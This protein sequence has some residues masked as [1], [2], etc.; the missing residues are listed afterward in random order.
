[1]LG[2]VRDVATAPARRD[3]LP[4]NAPLRPT[5]PVGPK[6][7]GLDRSR[8]DNRTGCPAPNGPEG[9]RS[10][11][12]SARAFPWPPPHRARHPHRVSRREP[13]RCSRWRPRDP[14]ARR[15]SALAPSTP[16]R[17]PRQGSHTVRVGV[18]RG[19]PRRRCANGQAEPKLYRARTRALGSR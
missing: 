11:K 8:E 19:S 5:R 9:P 18:G 7:A 17:S 6:P 1:M 2:C 3:A 15:P 13:A 10:V 12:R 14:K 16:R 4:R